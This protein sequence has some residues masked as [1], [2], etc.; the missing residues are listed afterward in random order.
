[1]LDAEGNF[2]RFYPDLLIVRHHNE[3]LEPWTHE[4]LL[5]S[6]GQGFLQLIMSSV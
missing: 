5:E 1:M 6:W 3:V 2:F 4:I